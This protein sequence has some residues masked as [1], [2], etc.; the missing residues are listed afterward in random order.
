MAQS[1]TIDLDEVTVARLEAEARRRGTGVT[2][3][4]REALIRGLPSAG[5]V[6]ARGGE[7][8][9]LDSLAGTWSAAD[10]EEFQA[11]VSV[12]GRVDDDLWK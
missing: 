10:A 11:A 1:I 5:T 4:A 6:S 12:F 9:D 7:Y 8:H 3:V 2:A